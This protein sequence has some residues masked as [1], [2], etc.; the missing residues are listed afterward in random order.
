MNYMQNDYSRQMGQ[1]RFDGCSIGFSRVY[2]SFNTYSNTGN[3]HIPFYFM[4]KNNEL[5]AW[6]SC[7]S[8]QGNNFLPTGAASDGRLDQ[9]SPFDDVF[10]KESCRKITKLYYKE[11]HAVRMY[12]LYFL[13]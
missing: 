11:N 3:Y 9:M 7:A 12:D 5:M 6:G 1:K 10:V 8:F 13:Y 2:T 4:H